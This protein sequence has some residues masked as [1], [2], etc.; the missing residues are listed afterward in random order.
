M[1]EAKRIL[2]L[3]VKDNKGW[4]EEVPDSLRP[5]WERWRSDLP[6]LSKLKVNR[7]FTP[8]DFGKV[9]KVE[10]HHFS[11]ASSYAYGQCSY[12]RI[13]DDQNRIHCSLV[14]AKARIAP[15][16]YVTVPRLELTAALVSV[17]VG[18]MLHD[19]I[20][21][22]N[23]THTYWTDSEI[24]LGY[25][26][27]ESKRFHIYVANRVQVIRENS[28]PEDWFY[29]CTKDNVADEVSRGMCPREMTESCRFL[30]GPE[31]LWQELP[32]DSRDSNHFSKIDIG[33]PEVKAVVM[34][35]S[36]QERYLTLKDGIWRYS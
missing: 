13:I 36:T 16:K 33:D 10:M 3:L 32:Q 29:I 27:N 28:K 21:Y 15:L 11:D 1:I 20:E 7:C 30:R 19:E 35:T 26:S 24:V 17:R 18:S 6:Q 23:I 4:D 31:F 14:M 2:Q 34:S 22:E 8:K 12:L 25:I 5:R 9:K